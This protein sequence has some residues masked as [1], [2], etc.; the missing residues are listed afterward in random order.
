MTQGGTA[1][2][3][4]PFQFKVDG[5]VTFS[6]FTP[7]SEGV[8][9]FI[10]AYVRE[11]VIWHKAGCRDLSLCD[12]AA[13][14]AAAIHC[15]YLDDAPWKDTR[16]WLGEVFGLPDD[17]TFME[18]RPEKI[19]QTM[20]R[21]L[22]LLRPETLALPERP[23]EGDRN[24]LIL[25]CP[26]EHF[27]ILGGDNRLALDST[28]L[29]NG[30]GCRP[31]P[32]PEAVTFA[33]STA[34]SISKHAFDI[35]EER[36]QVLIADAIRNGTPAAA[37]KLG[38]EV[39]LGIGERLGV[40]PGMAQVMISSSGTDTFLV[41]QGLI[42]LISDSPLVSLMVGA[43]ES[44]SGVPL[45]AQ[46]RH[47]AVTAAFGIEV[48]KGQPLG[49]CAND[50]SFIEVL[51]HDLNGATLP[52]KS[53]DQSVC[54]LVEDNLSTGAQV[55]IHAMNHSKLGRMGPSASL[56][57]KLKKRYGDRLHVV[58]DACQMRLD[59]DEL[60]EYLKYGFLVIITGSK[61]FTGPPLSGA[62]LVPRQI[63][64]RVPAATRTFPE[65][66]NAYCTSYD[67][68]SDLRKILARPGKHFNLG[69]YFRWIA[70]LAEMKRYFRVPFRVRKQTLDDVCRRFEECLL[71]R[72]CIEMQYE[73]NKRKNRKNP[74]ELSGRRMIF[75][76]FLKYLRGRQKQLCSENQVRTIYSLL[77][78]D[79]SG[80]FISEN[81][82][83]YRLLAQRCH[84]GQPVLTRHCSGQMSAVLRV[85]VGAR[86]IS[87]SWSKSSG[88]IMPDLINDEVWQVSVVLDKIELLLRK[89]A[90][91]SL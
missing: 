56:L 13:F 44:G 14:R 43:D 59:L 51:L 66:F 50:G 27:L 82:R 63:M 67:L 19:S 5:N 76:F 58:V 87:E 48:E 32:R 46:E 64:T 78:Q 24:L 39:R 37:K 81:A 4:L 89:I 20:L 73:I 62:V 47:F 10:S 65:S 31:F 3:R 15:Y 70:A 80:Q 6:P 41:N 69:S 84:I 9:I 86:V 35:V 55:V 72:S 88:R 28:T 8:R 53:V 40:K 18:F 71:A 16:N 52:A 33:S 68:P 26:V 21:M 91:A 22:S 49:G 42:R 38:D 12:L 60:R 54:K 85:S 36:R 29:L 7:A 11:W 2:L 1:N 45:A 77:N 79:C 90:D 61:F 23:A 17:L 25:A 34:T 74:G 57:L 30:Y 75:P 83:E